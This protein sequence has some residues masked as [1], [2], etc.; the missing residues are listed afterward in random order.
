M[1]V[2]FE[3]YLCYCIRWRIIY[4]DITTITNNLK[5][6]HILT[7]IYIYMYI[8]FHLKCIFVSIIAFKTEMLERD[9][10]IIIHF[11]PFSLNRKML[12]NKSNVP[13][14]KKG[15]E[16][17]TSV[18]RWRYEVMILIDCLFVLLILP[19]SRTAFVVILDLMGQQKL[20]FYAEVNNSQMKAQLAIVYR[21]FYWHHQQ[22]LGGKVPFWF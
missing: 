17:G 18:F 3:W 19:Y 2:R 20:K 15:E 4:H 12:T 14:N 8:S 22:K 7:H 10:Q 6:I 13:K 11:C 16:K 9:I 5:G 21:N 1:W